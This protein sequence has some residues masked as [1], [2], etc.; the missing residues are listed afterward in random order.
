[1]HLL[2]PSWSTWYVIVYFTGQEIDGSAFMRLN[3]NDFKDLF[4]KKLGIVKNLS[5]FQEKVTICMQ[6]S[7]KATKC[8]IYTH[9]SKISCHLLH[10][11]CS[12]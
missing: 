12:M 1:M 7:W 5:K 4:P 3:E 10:M 6:G 8:Y 11:A 2:F 9:W